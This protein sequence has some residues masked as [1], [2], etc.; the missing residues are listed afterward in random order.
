MLAIGALLVSTIAA[1]SGGCAASPRARRPD[2]TS[3]RRIEMFVSSPERRFERYRVGVDGI[4]HW[5]GGA[6]AQSAKFT[7]SG[8]L[9][10][11]EIEGLFGAI[12]RDG[13]F[14]HDPPSTNEPPDTIYNV[15]IRGPEGRESFIVTGE[16]EGLLEVHQILATASR[17]RLDVYLEALPQPG[18]QRQ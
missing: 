11:E 16:T 3:G 13:W 7:W 2:V 5:A 17:R 9:T 18:E 4:L 1:A 14:D 15:Q 10:A 6:N 8:P 12:E